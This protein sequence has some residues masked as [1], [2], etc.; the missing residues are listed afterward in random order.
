MNKYLEYLILAVVVILML[1]LTRFLAPEIETKEEKEEKKET[2]KV[3][4]NEIVKEAKAQ[5]GGLTSKIDGKK[6]V[7]YAKII[8]KAI[9]V[10]YDDEPAIFSVFKNL[11]TKMEVHAVSIAYNKLY[12]KDLFTVLKQNL[13]KNEMKELNAIIAKKPLK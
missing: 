1:R 3:F 12:N 7:E 13:N 11:K 10:L 2:N 4:S 9:G 5:K 8:N 6:A